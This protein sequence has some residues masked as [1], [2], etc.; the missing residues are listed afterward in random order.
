MFVTKRSSARHS[1]RRRGTL[2]RLPRQR[3]WHATGFSRTLFFQQCACSAQ[4][5][6]FP[7][8][9]IISRGYQCAIVLS[10]NQF[11]ISF[12]LSVPHPSIYKKHFLVRFSVFN[13]NCVSFKIQKQCSNI[14]KL[15]YIYHNIFQC[16]CFCYSVVHVYMCKYVC[17]CVSFKFGFY[18]IL[19]GLRYRMFCP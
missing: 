7:R 10:V 5:Y 17:E 19:F 11:E 2:A 18:D 8:R 15:S 1:C 4:T 6:E 13:N 16:P 12:C 9:C 14:I 3:R